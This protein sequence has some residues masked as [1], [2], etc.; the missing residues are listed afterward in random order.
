MPAPRGGEGTD[1]V[2][3]YRRVQGGEGTK[4]SQYRIHVDEN[5]KVTIPNKSKNLNISADSG[6]HSSY[7]IKNNRPGAEVVE[8]DVPKW[9][10][11]FV[12]ESAVSQAGYKSNPASQGGTV[13]KITDVTTPGK[14]IELPAPWIEWIEEYAVGGR[15]IKGGK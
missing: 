8:V 12:Q 14:S 15:V 7:Y 6:E 1:D 9:L 11:D 3:T 13:P 4:S 5:G 10:D 2:V